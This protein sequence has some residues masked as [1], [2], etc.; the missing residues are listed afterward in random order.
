ML[1]IHR[2]QTQGGIYYIINRKVACPLSSIYTHPIN[3]YKKTELL[4]IIKHEIYAF[5]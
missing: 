4:C 2:G 3:R 1:Q 5:P